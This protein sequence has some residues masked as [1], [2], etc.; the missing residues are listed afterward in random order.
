MLAVLD[1][2]INFIHMISSLR[3]DVLMDLLVRTVIDKNRYWDLMQKSLAR[4]II[5]NDL[6]KQLHKTCIQEFYM[7][8]VP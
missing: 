1:L 5:L 8:S 2:P 4:S 6:I 7:L 3:I